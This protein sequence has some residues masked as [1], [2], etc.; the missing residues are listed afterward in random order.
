MQSKRKLSRSPHHLGINGSGR[1][2]KIV[3]S[4]DETS[5]SSISRRSITTKGIKFNNL[6]P[7]AV[8]LPVQ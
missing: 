4:P 7:K 6:R 2:L 8:S 5:H 1:K 3:K